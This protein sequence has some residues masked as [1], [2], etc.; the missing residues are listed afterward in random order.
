M[1][2]KSMG[3]GDIIQTDL[4]HRLKVCSDAQKH[5]INPLTTV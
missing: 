1:G 5:T 2:Y 4:G 3:M